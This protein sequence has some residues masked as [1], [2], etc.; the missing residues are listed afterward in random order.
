MRYGLNTFLVSAG[1]TDADIPLIPQFKSYGAEVIELAICEP[2]AVTPAKVLKALESAD[3]PRPT[4]CGAFGPGKDLRGSEADRRNTVDYLAALIKIAEQ[5]GAKT[6]C[7]PFYSQVGHTKSY[8]PR[9]REEQLNRIAKTLGPICQKAEQAGVI[10]AM[11]P[12]NRFETDCINTLEQAVAL[13]ELV[14]SPA[15]KI[16]MDTFHMNIEEN[17]SG[18]AILAAGPH[19]GHV[20]ASASHRGLL[21]Q[22]QV[23]WDEVF[24]ALHAIG[25]NGDVVIESFSPGN[26]TI[27]KAASIWRSLYEHPEI[28]AVEGL[29]FLKQKRFSK[30]TQLHRA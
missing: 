30:P 15:L 26:V 7:G 9:E 5:L 6:I 25:Y 2:S 17:D 16:H 19:I 12:L 20:H 29:K 18:K 28:C 22:D 13:I 27:A 4:L 24:S 1:F 14:G 10:L 21:G 3:L 8:T 23:H 11:E